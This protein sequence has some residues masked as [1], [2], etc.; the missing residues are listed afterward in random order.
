MRTRHSFIMAAD[1]QGRVTLFD[2]RKPD[3][4]AW[5]A[6]TSDQGARGLDVA[7]ERGLFVTSSWDER[8]R[9]YRLDHSGS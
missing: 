7:W 5:E 1:S 8:V 9:L 6:R 3:T 4:F 2:A